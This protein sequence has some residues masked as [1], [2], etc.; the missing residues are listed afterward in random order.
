[1][2]NTSFVM[3]VSDCR[4]EPNEQLKYNL[5]LIILLLFGV[6]HRPTLFDILILT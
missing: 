5:F 4:L 3:G 2:Q 1:M 6:A